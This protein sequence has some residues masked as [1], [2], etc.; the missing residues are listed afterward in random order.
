MCIAAATIYQSQFITI[1]SGP[2][3]PTCSVENVLCCKHAAEYFVLMWNSNY[4]KAATAIYNVCR[5]PSR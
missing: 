2:T 5:V 3:T 4:K 1:T